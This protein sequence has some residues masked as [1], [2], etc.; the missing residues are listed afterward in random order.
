MNGSDSFEP[1]Y[2]KVFDVM[3][4]AALSYAMIAMPYHAMP[5]HAMLLSIRR[6]FAINNVFTAVR[7]VKCGANENVSR[8][9]FYRNYV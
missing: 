3:R 1:P 4:I 6:D 9:H 7:C 5:R 2:T 8:S